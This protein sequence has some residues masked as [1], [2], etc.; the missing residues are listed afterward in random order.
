MLAAYIQYK[1]MYMLQNVHF[2][3]RIQYQIMNS[4]EMYSSNRI[5]I[6]YCKHK[7]T[8]VVGIAYIQPTIGIYICQLEGFCGPF[9]LV[10]VHFAIYICIG[11]Q[12][13]TFGEF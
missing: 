7:K 2:V 5:Q 3:I 8:Y 11:Y 12:L 6:I 13:P 9:E 4:T 1:Y 10:N